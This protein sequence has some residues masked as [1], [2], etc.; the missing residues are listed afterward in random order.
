MRNSLAT[1]PDYHLYEKCKRRLELAGYFRKVETAH[2]FFQ[3]NQWGD[4][5]P[6]NMPRPVINIVEPIVS[7][8]VAQIS[9]NGMYPYVETD[10]VGVGDAF[11]QRIAKIWEKQ[12]LDNL[13]YEVLQS[14]AIAGISAAYC[15]FD[16]NLKDVVC[17]I[18]D[19]RDIIFSCETETDIEKQDFI[20][21][22][23]TDSVARVKRE[24]EALGL[25]PQHIE[26]IRK[27]QDDFDDITDRCVCVLKLWKED[28]VVHFSKFTRHVVLVEDENTR[29]ETYPLSIMPWGEN[30]RH[31][32]GLGEISKIL[33]NQIE[34]NKNYARRGV[35]IM[36][37]AYPRIA[38]LTDMVENPEAIA[39]VGS[40]IGVSGN[41]VADVAKAITY[42]SPVR[43]STDA[44]TYTAELI[45]L[46]R[47]LAGAS[48]N[49]IGLVNPE[50][51]S[52]T[53]ILAVQSAQ[54]LPLA[55]QIAMMRK[56]VEKLG[57]IWLD[58]YYTYLPQGFTSE[59]G[60][61]ISKAAIKD[62][63][64]H[65]KVEI[66]SKNPFTTTAVETMLLKYLEMGHITFEEYC[67]LLPNGGVA[68]SVLKNYAPRE[69]GGSIQSENLKN[70]L[71]QTAL[72]G[73]GQNANANANINAGQ[74]ANINA[75]G[76]NL[77]GGE[78]ANSASSSEMDSQLFAR[79]SKAAKQRWSGSEIAT[80]DGSGNTTKSKTTK[81]QNK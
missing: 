46:T 58:L 77:A 28:G 32:R 79:V 75:G 53:A 70:L 78:S 29:L 30:Y 8:K 7:Y 64:E 21:L 52:G 57:R 36:D 41:S 76:M 34:I 49:S 40:A 14:S 35:S 38:Y 2:E 33:Q 61:K 20:M 47:A 39:E 12:D 62:A 3:G 1:I 45:E 65:I 17:E 27:E 42:L 19:A 48:D 25:S 23:Y 66:S 55:R 13:M 4:A 80:N 59:D 54:A 16:E 60:K 50:A 69:N 51:A 44:E 73:G 10:D 26:M 63:M 71:A 72:A 5:P 43:I 67:K 56:F 11:S 6:D 81:N 18:K 24:A 37:G 31:I 15:Y 68:Q 9:Q 74:N 22:P